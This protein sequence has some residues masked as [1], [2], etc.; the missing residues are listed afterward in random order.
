MVVDHRHRAHLVDVGDA[1]HYLLH[2]QGGD[3]GL[4]F[5]KGDQAAGNGAA[6]RHNQHHKEANR[7]DRPILIQQAGGEA[8]GQGQEGAYGKVDAPGDDDEQHTVGQDGGGGVLGQ[9]IEQV[10]GGQKLRGQ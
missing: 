3:E 4:D 8:H 9:D 2:G 6:R 10:Q 1:P 7:R 5:A